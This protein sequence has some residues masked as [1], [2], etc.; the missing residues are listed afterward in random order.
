MQLGQFCGI[1]AWANMQPVN[2][3]RDQ[4][5]EKFDP[6]HGDQRHVS[7]WGYRISHIDHIFIRHLFHVLSLLLPSPRPSL[8]HR[9]DPRPEVR[10]STSSG[11]ASPRKRNKMLAVEDKFRHEPNFLV[12]HF[13]GVKIFDFVLLLLMRCVC[14][15]MFYLSIW[16]CFWY[17]VVIYGLLFLIIQPCYNLYICLYFVQ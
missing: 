7:E 3:L 9:I 2:I 13:L 17:L 8:K 6:F 10:H 5:L 15:W 12:E 1:E 11:Y 4:V 14:H 16:F